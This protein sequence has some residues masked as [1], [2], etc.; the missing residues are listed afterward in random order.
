MLAAMAVQLD[1]GATRARLLGI[2]VAI[3]AIAVL[4]TYF[5]HLGI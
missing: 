5:W 3:A 4:V 1:W 2:A